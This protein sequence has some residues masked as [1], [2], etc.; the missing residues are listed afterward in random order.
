MAKPVKIHFIE[1][2]EYKRSLL[3]KESWRYNDQIPAL[4]V[5]L[6]KCKNVHMA[7][8]VSRQVRRLPF[9]VVKKHVHLQGSL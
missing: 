9:T 4:V 1:A 2:F 7:F 8:A 6:V 5:T 3:I